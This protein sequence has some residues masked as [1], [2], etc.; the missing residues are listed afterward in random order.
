VQRTTAA[1]GLAI[2][3]AILTSQQ[4][5]LMADRTALIPS[6]TPL[7][8][9]GAS[10]DSG[11]V[12]A[13]AVY[14]QTQNQV[15]V[16]GLNDLYVIT[17]ALTAVGVVLALMLRSGPVPTPAG[18]PAVTPSEGAAPASRQPPASEPAPSAP[19]PRPHDRARAAEPVPVLAGAAS[20]TTDELRSNGPG[21][22]DEPVITAEPR[23]GSRRR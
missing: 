16:S 1:L 5:Q 19:I 8:D 17:A 14:Q 2:L 22:T 23:P 9:L 20:G 6:A 7:P 4:A 13:L 18:G 3:T 11:L 10:A 12:G 15:F 21:R